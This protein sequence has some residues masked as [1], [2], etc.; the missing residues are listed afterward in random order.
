MS[1]LTWYKLFWMSR[2]SL[3]NSCINRWAMTSSSWMI[4]K[5]RI[6]WEQQRKRTRFIQH[7]CKNLQSYFIWHWAIK[8][9]QKSAGLSNKRFNKKILPHKVLTLH[10]KRLDRHFEQCMLCR[11]DVSDLW[12]QELCSKCPKGASMWSSKRA[13]VFAWKV[14][15]VS[16]SKKKKEKHTRC[17]SAQLRL[18]YNNTK[19]STQT[20]KQFH[21]FNQSSVM[22]INNNPTIHTVRKEHADLK[23]LCYVDITVLQNVFHCENF[24]GQ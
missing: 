17:I 24:K 8:P 20:V 4:A 16:V 23:V 9:P 10:L 14:M 13:S 12:T 5:C 2:T 21:L 6:L 3:G 19:L 1:T 15:A 22:K 18:L 11:N 7:A